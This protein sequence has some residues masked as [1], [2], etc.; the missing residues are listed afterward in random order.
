MNTRHHTHTLNWPRLHSLPYL[1][2]PAGYFECIR[3]LPQPVWLDSGRPALKLGRYDILAADPVETLCLQSA[4]LQNDLARLRQ[5]LGTAPRHCH[6]A[7]PFCGGLIGY[8]GYEAGRAWQG[9]PVHQ[10]DRL[11]GDIR[12]GLYDWALVVDH[13]RQSATLVGM[14]LAQST[15]DHWAAL[16]ERLAMPVPVDPP[17]AVSGELLDSGLAAADYAEAFARIQR[18]IRDGDIYQ[19]NFTRRFNARSAAE[20]W[21]LYRRLRAISPAPYGAYLDLGDCQVLSNSPEQFLSLHDGRVQTR[22]IK[23]TRPRGLNPQQDARLLADLAASDKERAENL[24]IV[25]LLRNDI[26]RVCEPG[27]IE[28]PELFAIESYATVHHLVSTVVGRLGSGRDAFDLLGACFPGGSITGAPKRRA[29]Q[30]IDELESRGRELYCGSIFRLGYDGNLD[31]SISIRTLLR[32][33]EQLYYW[34]GG[35]IVAD[36]DCDAEYQ[37]SLDKAAA[38]LGLLGIDSP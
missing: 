19:V 9:M 29:M 21:A 32:L 16:C 31:S 38:F 14:G 33:D 18:Y 12:A 8:L 3:D 22:P 2:D 23:G 15:R 17:R 20:P 25:D 6:P 35:G 1:A 4:G 30:V 5:A 28:V 13:H 27:S 26:G 37:E 34:A 7:L 11:A 10:S 24:M 36:S